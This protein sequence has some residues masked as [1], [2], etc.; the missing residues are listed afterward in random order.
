M[1]NSILAILVLA[2]W[3]GSIKTLHAQPADFYLEQR[4]QIQ[5]LDSL[6]T[7]SSDISP[8]FVG[9]DFY[10]SSVQKSYWGSRSRAKRN[11]LFYDV[12]KEPN[13]GWNV[14]PSAGKREP[15][16]GFGKDFHEGPIDYC[17]ATGELFATFSNVVNPDSIRG[18]FPKNTIRLRLVTM[19]RG[20]DGNWAIQEEFPYNDKDFSFAH[21][22]ISI[23]GDSLVFTSNMPG[24]YGGND[25]YLCTRNVKSRAWS[26][27]QNLGEHINSSGDEMFPTFLPGGFLSFASNGREGI[28][29]LDV[30]YTRLNGHSTVTSLPDINTGADEFGFIVTPGLEYGYFVSNRPG[31]GED[32]IYKVHLSPKYLQLLVKVV[33]AETGEL[34][35]NA[36]L[37][38]MQGENEVEIDGEG[39]LFEMRLQPGEAKAFHAVATGYMWK[40]A[41]YRAEIGQGKFS[42]EF[43]IPLQKLEVKKAFVLENLYFDLDKSNIRPDAQLVLG[44][45]IK[46]LNDNPDIRIELGSHTDSRASFAY[47]E[48]L[49]ER[50]SASVVQYLVDHGIAKNRL[51]AKGYGE[52][53]LVN[54]CAD[55]VFC[56]E[57]DHQANRRTEFKVIE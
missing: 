8:C 47:N 2:L 37:A 42:Y 34:I 52:T 48:R 1:K 11:M 4:Y 29:G 55:G 17:E 14:S 38:V 20:A 12:Y 41:A 9:N 19:T 39:G 25:L 18:M 10:Y 46:I 53:Q 30:Y 44:R 31:K 43:V 45:L 6:N 7:V 56:S 28:G 22:A 49:S 23:T 3:A 35:P 57:E 26:A 5:T 36:V 50:R 33:D 24:G 51:E 27:P 13:Q 32:D 40:D 21:P 15:G 54:N 16:G